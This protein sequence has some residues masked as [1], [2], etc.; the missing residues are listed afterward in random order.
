[1]IGKIVS[2]IAFFFFENIFPVSG[3]YRY[4]GN[5]DRSIDVM[6]ALNR[7]IPLKHRSTL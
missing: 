5:T 1:M 7:A 4:Q 6:A 3:E 2:Q